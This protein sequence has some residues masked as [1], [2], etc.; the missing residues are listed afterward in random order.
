MGCFLFSHFLCSPF[1]KCEW[2]IANLGTVLKNILEITYIHGMIIL[3]FVRPQVTLATPCL[4][5][6]YNRNIVPKKITKVK[7]ILLYWTH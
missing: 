5:K 1:A 7:V 2:I 4:S 6:S 3:N